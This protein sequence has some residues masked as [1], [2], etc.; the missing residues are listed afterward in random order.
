MFVEVGKMNVIR[1]KE[2]EGMNRVVLEEETERG[3]YALGQTRPGTIQWRCSSCGLEW[4]SA[5][6]GEGCPLEQLERTFLGAD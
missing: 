2:R 4:E 6:Y 1:E 3:Q 5:Q